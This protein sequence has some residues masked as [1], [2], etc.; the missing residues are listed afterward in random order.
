MFSGVNVWQIAESK[1][2]GEIKFGEW[3]EFGHKN[4]IYTLKFDFGKPSM[5]RQICQ[6]FPLP[7]IS[8]IQYILNYLLNNYDVVKEFC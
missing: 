7:N 6:T 8:A 3:I 2:I 1:I 5:T 4:T